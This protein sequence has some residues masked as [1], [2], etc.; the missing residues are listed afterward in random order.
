MV[1]TWRDAN[2]Y[3]SR[4][5]PTNGNVRERATRLGGPWGF[6]PARDSAASKKTK[7]LRNKI[8][9]E[10]IR[11]RVAF[12]VAGPR[13]HRNRPTVHATPLVFQSLHRQGRGD[14]E[15]RH[16][17]FVIASGRRAKTA[18]DAAGRG[19]GALPIGHEG[20]GG[21]RFARCPLVTL[22]GDTVNA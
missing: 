9:P 14:Y 17:A 7:W 4:A 16:R 1:S 19:W 3:A 8:N 13:N 18:S 10:N 21:D 2:L 15:R 20:P 6:G 22:W 5:S 11:H 12:S